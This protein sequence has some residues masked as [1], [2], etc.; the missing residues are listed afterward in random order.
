[1]IN[2][3]DLGG[4]KPNLKWAAS[5]EAVTL[6]WLSAHSIRTGIGGDN[7][8]VDSPPRLS[9][10]KFRAFPG[11]KIDLFQFEK[12]PPKPAPNID[13]HRATVL[14]LLVLEAA[15]LPAESAGKIKDS[16]VSSIIAK[17]TR[18]SDN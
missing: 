14:F 7:Y 17:W 6:P 9:R 12:I 4:G 2:A 11:K 5:Q 18:H 16:I 3:S 15:L 10:I 8:I 1:V 13:T